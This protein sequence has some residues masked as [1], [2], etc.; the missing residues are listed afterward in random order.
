[1]E[2]FYIVVSVLAVII[3]I[4]ALTF[5]GLMIQNG[6][7]TQKFPPNTSQCPDLWIPDGSYCHYNGLNNGTYVTYTS[8]VGATTGSTNN[9]NFLGDKTITNGT[10]VNKYD[11]SQI[12]ITNDKPTKYTVTNGSTTSSSSIA[13]HPMNTAPFFTYGGTI[14]KNSTTINPFD[15]QW[16]TAGL[17]ADCAKKK[18]AK[19]NNIEWSGITQLNSC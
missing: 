16:G 3:L 12:G 15:P 8:G 11:F 5:I 4:L 6:N 17:S 19:L 9:G 18:W 2:F 7:K 13:T 10:Y 1:M 14:N